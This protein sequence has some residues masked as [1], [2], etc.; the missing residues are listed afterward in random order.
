MQSKSVSEIS[1]E[2]FLNRI[3]RAV[4]QADALVAE[5]IKRLAKGFAEERSKLEGQWGRGD[6]VFTEDLCVSLPPLPF[7]L[8]P[9][10]ERLAGTL[11]RL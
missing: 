11:G 3:E 6:D 4:E 2:A 8:R 9:I 1:R 7:L 5:V 10:A